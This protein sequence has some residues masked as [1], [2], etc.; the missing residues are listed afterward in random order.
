M[1]TSDVLLIKD[2]L[3]KLK[4]PFEYTV[5]I[6]SRTP[7]IIF[8][9]IDNYP[10]LNGAPDKNTITNLFRDNGFIV[11]DVQEQRYKYANGIKTELWVFVSDNDG[12]I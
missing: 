12:D 5:N 9:L 6:K 7:Q 8:R 2:V 10:T 3:N 4:I 1:K 11:V